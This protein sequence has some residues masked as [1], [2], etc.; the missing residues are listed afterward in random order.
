MDWMLL[1]FD[2][3]K[4]LLRTHLTYHPYQFYYVTMVLNLAFRLSWLLTLSPSIV[5]TFKSP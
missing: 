1:E 5:S 4:K 3:P 2:A